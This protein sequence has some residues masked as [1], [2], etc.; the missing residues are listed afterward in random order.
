MKQKLS[1]LLALL[2]CLPLSAFSKGDKVECK[3]KPS[4]SRY[5]K[6]KVLSTSGDTLT[7]KFG[8]RRKEYEVDASNCRKRMSFQEKQRLR[9]RE[10]VK[11]EIV[12]TYNRYIHKWKAKKSARVS[13]RQYSREIKSKAF[14]P[15]DYVFSLKTGKMTK[16]KLVSYLYGLGDSAKSECITKAEKKLQKTGQA[17]R[18]Y[19]KKGQPDFS[20]YYC[21]KSSYI[22]WVYKKP[23]RSKGRLRQE[24][25]HIHP[26]TGKILKKKID[27][28]NKL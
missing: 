26:K 20:N 3:K 6:A 11:K 7:V 17:G 14:I 18:L 2:F 25:Y 24:I 1:F 5:L 13:A 4:S 12:K 19:R 15:D 22:L 8:S 27:T 9:Y 23:L 10:G 16:K 21:S 28:S